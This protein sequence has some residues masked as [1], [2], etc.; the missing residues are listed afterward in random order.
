M[1]AIITEASPVGE[2][3]MSCWSCRA[4][5]RVSLEFNIGHGKD[6]YFYGVLVPARKGLI[7]AVAGWGRR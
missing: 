4:G 5:D 7:F 2:A 3:C 6:L 1:V